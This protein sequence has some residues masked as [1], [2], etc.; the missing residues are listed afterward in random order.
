MCLE[1][2]KSREYLRKLSQR[3]KQPGCK[4]VDSVALPGREYSVRED[5]EMRK[6]RGSLRKLIIAI[7]LN[8]GQNS[9]ESK[10]RNW[11]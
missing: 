8:N 10:P 9:H 2:K 7:P 11:E 4:G 5:V 1:L 6:V 3:Y